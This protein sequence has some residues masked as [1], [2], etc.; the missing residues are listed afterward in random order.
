MV[1][2]NIYVHKKNHVDGTSMEPTLQDGQSVY[3]TMLPYIFG[4]PEIGDIVVIDIDI[5]ENDSTYFRLFKQTLSGKS[6]T[7]WIKRIVGLPGDQIAFKNKQFYRN[8]KLVAEDYIKEHSDKPYTIY[9]ADED[10]EYD[11]VVE[12]DLSKV[13]PT[14]AFPHLPGNAH[15]IDEVE[16]MEPSKL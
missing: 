16:A 9:E 14:V 7:F 8:G 3:T 2:F 12:V 11:D 6:D 4:E 10:A 13:R 15:T 1:T 5:K